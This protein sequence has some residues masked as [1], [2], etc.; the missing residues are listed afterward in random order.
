M[1]DSTVKR[2]A[3]VLAIQAEIEGMKM[4]NLQ[5]EIECLAPAYSEG[6]FMSAAEDLRNLANNNE[7]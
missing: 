7:L 2:L 1:E 4:A 5:R 3:L 6:Y